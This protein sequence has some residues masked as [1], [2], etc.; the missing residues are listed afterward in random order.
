MGYNTG[1]K[2]SRKTKLDEEQK[3]KKKRRMSSKVAQRNK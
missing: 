3:K 1:K 2:N